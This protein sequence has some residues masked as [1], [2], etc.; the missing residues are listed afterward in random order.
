M[1]ASTVKLFIFTLSVGLVSFS[2]AA[3]LISTGV[4]QVGETVVTSREVQISQAI[5]AALQNGKRTAIKVNQDVDSPSFAK[6]VT[7]VLLERVVYL[8]A[9]NVSMAEVEET[10]LNSTESRVRSRLAHSPDW[11]ALK[12]SNA[13]FSQALK[14]KTLAKKFIRFRAESSVVPVADSEAKKY[15][16]Q[17]RL[18]FGDLPFENFKASIKTYLNKIQVESRLKSWFEVLQSKYKVRNFLSES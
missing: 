17:N 2:E 14:R 16:E 1:I 4:G 15:F 12:V 18:K 6:D 7:A 9:K 10:T 11:K 8:E 13:E 5:E 3:K